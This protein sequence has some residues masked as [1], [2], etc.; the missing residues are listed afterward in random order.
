MDRFAQIG[1]I[2]LNMGGSEIEFNYVRFIGFGLILLWMLR[3]RPGGLLPESRLTRM[4]TMWS[5]RHRSIKMTPK[6]KRRTTRRAHSVDTRA[7]LPPTR[8]V[9]VSLGLAPL[10]L[11]AG[12]RGREMGRNSAQSSRNLS[13]A[14]RSLACYYD[15]AARTQ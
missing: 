14:A 6:S 10:P 7:K 4:R 1:A 8:V 15:P 2:V 13:S 9:C 5:A 11:L 12:A 3:Y